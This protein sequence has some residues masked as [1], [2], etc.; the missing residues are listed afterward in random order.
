[1]SWFKSPV[2]KK[3][4]VNIKKRNSSVLGTSQK[5]ELS[6]STG[7]DEKRNMATGGTNPPAA[8][9][10]NIPASP[11]L[12]VPEVKTPSLEEFDKIVHDA[13]LDKNHEN[14]NGTDGMSYAA[15]ARKAKRS[16]PFALYILAGSEDRKNLTK[17]H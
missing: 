15:K 5:G 1:M 2:K 10:Q 8:G 13:S 12:V 6:G 14:A 17:P 4:N 7:A 11:S 3:D 16:Y 9:T